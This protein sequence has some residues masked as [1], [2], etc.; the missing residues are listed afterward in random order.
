MHADISEDVALA[1]LLKRRGYRVHIAGGDA[2]FETRMYTGWQ[3]LWIGVSKNLVDMMGGPAATVLAA[4]AGL[5]LSW[6][7]IALPVA[8]AS[9]AR[10]GPAAWPAL[11]AA[12]PASL[13]VFAFH[14]AGAR[15]FGIPA[16]Y[17]LLFPLG[18]TCG[19]AMAVD[20]VRRRATGRTR[21]KGRIYP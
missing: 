19:A 4:G 6:M 13:A 5:I 16:W 14:L 20:S 3:S 11:A 18:Y 15:H 10:S 8:A 12:S 1:R 9:A 7:A 2:L 17:G 21:W